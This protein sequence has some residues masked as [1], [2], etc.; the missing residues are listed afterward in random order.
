LFDLVWGGA[1]VAYGSVVVGLFIFQRRILYRPRTTRPA[2]EELVSIGV[3]EVTLTTADGLDLLA[4]FLPP[5]PGRPV[6]LFFHGN[7]GHLG[8]RSGRLLRFA[9]E[10]YG[11]LL[12]EYRGYGGNPGAPCEAGLFADGAAALDFLACSG[13]GPDRIVLWGESL[14]SGVAV[15][16]AATRPVAALVLEA[17]FTSVTACARRRY[18]FVPVA[19]LL[20]D[21]F[22]S[23]SRIA[24]VTAP[25]LVLHGERDR[26]VPVRHSRALLAAATASKEGWFCPQAN[27][28]D[29]AEFGALDTA[30]D[31]IERRICTD[32]AE[33][34]A[35]AANCD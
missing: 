7:C 4:W 11:V 25:L 12:A 17:P 18:A 23:M 2:L 31:F 27:H 21:R 15:Y 33:P 5:A 24:R 8:Y 9:R 29:L 32:L 26:V 13:I 22:D 19:L 35:A 16:L 10:G 20:R 1:A 34:V 3:R 6:I 14:G 30:I 28:V